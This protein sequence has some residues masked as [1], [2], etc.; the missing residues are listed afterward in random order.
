MASFILVAGACH[1]AWCWQRVVP[2][3][4]AAGHDTVTTDLLGMGKDR[5]S[6]AKATLGAWADQMAR[7]VVDQEQPVVLVGHSRGGIVI[8]ETAERVPDHIHTL[9]YL[10]AILAA[11]G[12][13]LQDAAQT[14]SRS[15]HSASV[16]TRNADG[17]AMTF[18]PDALERILYNTTEP[19]W[20]AC[21]KANVGPEPMTS[22]TTP[23]HLSKER[24]GRLRRAYIE[25]SDD[26]T[27]PLSLQRTMQAALPCDPVVTMATDHSPFFSA[28]QEL[29]KN[30]M[31]IAQVTA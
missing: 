25:C 14:D 27:I 11:N 19:D 22:F 28:P 17:T 16:V 30:L 10:T 31:A 9:V 24:Y 13:T 23:L 4:E 29:A 15:D 5:T 18:R 2:L 3:L 1:G 7:I 21:A 8:S 12:Q 6:L 26:K 20:V